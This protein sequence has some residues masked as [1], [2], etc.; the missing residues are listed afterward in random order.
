MAETA[1]KTLREQIK[2]YWVF[3]PHK[4][5]FIERMAILF[6]KSPITLTNHWFGK[7]WMIPEPYQE[8]VLEE[9]KKEVES[10]P[11]QKWKR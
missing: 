5:S 8:R 9:I 4:T 6:E 10:A 7:F 11:E 3:V 2:N 1:E